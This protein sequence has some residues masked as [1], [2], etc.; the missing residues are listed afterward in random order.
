MIILIIKRKVSHE[1]MKITIYVIQP[2]KYPHSLPQIIKQSLK[3]KHPNIRFQI[4][5]N[6]IKKMSASTN[7]YFILNDPQLKSWDGLSISKKIRQNEPNSPLILAS[8]IIN[9]TQFF[10][11]H[12]GFLGIIN[13]H[14]TSQNEI[15]SYL[16]DSIKL[17]IT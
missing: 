2:L 16:E 6:Y 10:R 17:V 11:S 14:E 5:Q 9:Y 4:K 13:L 15:E 8:T 3:E 12:I 1:N 7:I